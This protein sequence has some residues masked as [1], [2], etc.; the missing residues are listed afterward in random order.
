M[1]APSA[2][3]LATVLLAACGRTAVTILP[4]AELPEDVYGSP[5]PSRVEELPDHGTVYLV[6]KRKLVGIPREL[7]EASSLPEALLKALLAGPKEAH[8]TAIPQDARL[9]SVVIDGGGIATV[10]LSSEFERSAPGL[11][12]ALRVAQVVY[13]LTEAPQV[14]AVRF[15]IEG[16]PA[17]VIAANDRVVVRPVARADYERFAPLEG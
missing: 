4:E 17:G 11:Q 3:L 5:T 1:K 12:L 10:D 2:L 6:H 16:A 7:P 13:T 14:R 9:I 15:S 8:R